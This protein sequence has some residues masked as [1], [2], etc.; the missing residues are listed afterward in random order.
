MLLVFRFLGSNLRL[1][2]GTGKVEESPFTLHVISYKSGK[3]AIAAAATSLFHDA[4]ETKTSEFVSI[5]SM[6]LA[7]Q[8]LNDILEGGRLLQVLVFQGLTEHRDRRIWVPFARPHDCSPE[9][10]CCAVA[11]TSGICRFPTLA[12]ASYRNKVSSCLCGLVQ[13]VLMRFEQLDYIS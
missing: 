6:R 8:R 1:C 2:L 5:T 13:C 9:T 4:R 10:T 11:C 7:I 12:T 3:P